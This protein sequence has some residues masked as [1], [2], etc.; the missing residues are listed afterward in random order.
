MSHFLH[1]SS[2]HFL[3][4]ILF[5]IFLLFF[6]QNISFST[7]SHSLPL[8]HFSFSPSCCSHNLTLSIFFPCF[9]FRGSSNILQSVVCEAALLPCWSCYL[10]FNLS[11]THVTLWK[12]KSCQS[13]KKKNKQK[14]TLWKDLTAI[15]V[16]MWEQPGCFQPSQSYFLYASTYEIFS[17]DPPDVSRKQI[18]KIWASMF[19]FVCFQPWKDALVTHL[20]C[21]YRTDRLPVPCQQSLGTSL[22]NL[23]LSGNISSHT[24]SLG[25][26]D[27]YNFTLILTV[28]IDTV[29]HFGKFA[30]LM[31]VRNQETSTSRTYVLA[32]M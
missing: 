30:F 27:F 4:P 9:S 25:S 28:Y 19:P 7:T 12:T 15:L 10:C 8:S 22:P 21:L 16:Q 26:A 24:P 23:N 31:R 6:L 11:L 3:T 20:L 5:F 32:Y 2:S 18:L 29:W 17:P 13:S 1:S 14:K